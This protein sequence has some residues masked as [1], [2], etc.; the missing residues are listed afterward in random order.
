MDG[1]EEAGSPEDDITCTPGVVP[2]RALVTSV[3]TRASMV[4]AFTIEA[5]PVNELLVAVPYATTMVSSRN[6]LS[7]SRATLWIPLDDTLTSLDL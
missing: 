5:E 2:A 1:P 6:S 4:S 3:A 7:G